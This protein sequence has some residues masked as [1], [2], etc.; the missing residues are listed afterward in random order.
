MMHRIHAPAAPCVR[1]CV[2]ANTCQSSSL[3]CDDSCVVVFH[4]IKHGD[5]C[6]WIWSWVAVSVLIDSGMKYV[7]SPGALAAP[8][9]SPCVLWELDIRERDEK[10]IRKANDR[11]RLD[12]ML[13]LER[14]SVGQFSRGKSMA[15]L[16]QYFKI[17]GIFL[18]EIE[19]EFRTSTSTY[20]RA[21]ILQSRAHALRV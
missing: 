11:P 15:C 7:Q 4:E 14:G 9:S 17:S 20:H 5:F 12:I 21:K 16:L 8:L 18:G 1:E 3:P 13:A 6:T 19:N 10:Y 2:K